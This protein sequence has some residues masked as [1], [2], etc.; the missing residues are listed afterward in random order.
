MERDSLKILL[1]T[2]LAAGAGAGAGSLSSAL[3][4]GEAIRKVV[5]SSPEIAEVR[6]VIGAVKEDLTEIREEQKEQRATIRETGR[7]VDRVLVILEERRPD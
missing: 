6:A 5:S 2:L 4:D 3:A 7:K 1:A